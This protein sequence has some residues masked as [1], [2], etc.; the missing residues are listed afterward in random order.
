MLACMINCLINH[1][2]G[3]QKDHVC[4]IVYKVFWHEDIFQIAN[5]HNLKQLTP[6]PWRLCLM[7][8]NYLKH[9]ALLFSNRPSIA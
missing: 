2:R 7:N 1:C 4:K 9:L 6:A 5:A 3:S 8:Q